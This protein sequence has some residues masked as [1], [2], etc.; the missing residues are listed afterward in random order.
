MDQNN[1]ER[2]EQL[3]DELTRL[4]G[5]NDSYVLKLKAFWHIHEQEYGLAKDLLK[6]VLIS[7]EIDL[8]AGINMA[9]IEI[10][11]SQT[12]KAH[13]RLVK[14]QNIYPENNRIAELIQ[15]LNL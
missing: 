10:K 7:N 4:K 9:V 14:L 11:T 6:E 13:Q 3:F 5:A 2:T 15:N 12:Q 1:V 8:N